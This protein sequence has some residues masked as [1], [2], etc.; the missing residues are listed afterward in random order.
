[1]EQGLIQLRH[2]AHHRGRVGSQTHW[3]VLVHQ[4]GFVVGVSLHRRVPLTDPAVFQCQVVNVRTQEGRDRLGGRLDD[5]L[6]R[7]VEACVE[8][9]RR[10][11]ATL[12]QG[13]AQG[14][15]EGVV[16]RGACLDPPGTIRVGMA[17]SSS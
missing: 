14:V 11:I 2:Q 3:E 1:M 4:G 13:V 9:H 6:P 16:I 5:G 8:Q 17:G 7:H 10:P 12:C 15:E